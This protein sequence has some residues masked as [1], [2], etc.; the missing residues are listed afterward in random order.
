MHT[1]KEFAEITGKT[2]A[3]GVGW[4]PSEEL[5][6]IIGKLHQG[7]FIMKSEKQKLIDFSDTFLTSQTTPDEI[8]QQFNDIDGERARDIACLAKKEQE[9]ICSRKCSTGNISDG[10]LYH[11]PR[12]P[13]LETVLCSLLDPGIETEVAEFMISCSTEIKMAVRKKF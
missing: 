2:H 7:E 8:S 13:S 1:V 11:F 10:C 5:S 12:L 6:L 3:H 9:H 4:L